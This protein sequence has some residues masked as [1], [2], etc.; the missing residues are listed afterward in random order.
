MRRSAMGWI[1]GA[2][3][4]ASACAFRGEPEPIRFWLLTSLE[5]SR[6]SGD[7]QR[8]LVVGPVQFPSYLRRSEIARRVGPHEL[9][10]AAFDRWADTLD[11]QFVQVLA[12]NLEI[13]V[14]GTRA[15]PFPWHGGAQ[16]ELQ[17]VMNVS[18]FAAD[19]Q[20]HVSLDVRW[21]LFSRRRGQEYAAGTFQHREQAEGAG[22]EAVAEAMSRA[23]A[24]LSR[25]VAA[26]LAEAPGA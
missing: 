21:S 22:Y 9:A 4:L 17:V 19:A 2:A 12:D 15:A 6:A 7:V 11:R 20:G 3:L 25:E 18:R 24:A 10:V 13:L 16:P 14:P 1:L 23:L 5:G 26:A 8:K